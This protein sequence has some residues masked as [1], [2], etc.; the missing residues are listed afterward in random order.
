MCNSS[1]NGS[2]I[3]TLMNSLHKHLSDQSVPDLFHVGETAMNKQN[4]NSALRGA[5][6]S[7]LKSRDRGKIN[8]EN[9]SSM[10]KN[11]TVKVI[12]REGV[13]LHSGYPGPASLRR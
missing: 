12:E 13:K 6:H 1:N 4:K 8:T 10:D 7:G 3:R 5:L 9:K 11:N 2:I